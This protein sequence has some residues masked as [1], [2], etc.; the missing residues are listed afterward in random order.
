MEGSWR[1][2]ACAGEQRV[3]AYTPKRNE[4]SALRSITV[5]ASRED[6]EWLI[7]RSVV[8]RSTARNRHDACLTTLARQVSHKKRRK[9]RRSSTAEGAQK[10]GCHLPRTLRRSGRARL[11]VLAAEVGGR[12]SVETA[13][14]CLPSPMPRRNWHHIFSEAGWRLLGCAGGA[15]FWPAQHHGP[16]QSLCWTS[17]QCQGRVTPSRPLTRL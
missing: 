2:L 11:V 9:P 1:R 4:E 3:R 6:G 16:S 5:Q 14:F 15:P 8:A 10:E 13:Q 17:A 7:Q 12:W